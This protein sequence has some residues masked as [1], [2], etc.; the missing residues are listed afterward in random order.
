MNQA[1]LVS[2]RRILIILMG[3]LGDVVRGLAIADAIKASY[4]SIEIDWLVEPK[5]E[6]IVRMSP[7]INTVIVFK[8]A[9]PLRGF[10]KLAS[11]F[12]E[13]SYDIVLD[14]QRHFKSGCFSFLTGAE[15][16]IGFHRRD[17]KE[18]NFL[19]STETISHT[20]TIE[21]KFFH[22]QRFLDALGVARPQSTRTKLL[23]PESNRFIDR[24]QKRWV[25]VTLGSSWLS[26]NW[27]ADSYVSVLRQLLARP[28]IHIVLIGGADQQEIAR[29]IRGQLDHG[30]RVVDAVGQTTLQE[31]CSIIALS[32]AGFGPDSGPGHL[33]AAL[34][35]PYVSLFGPTDPRL[36]APVGLDHLV[37]RSGVG[38][39]PCYRRQCPGLGEVCMRNLDTTRVT[40]KVLSCLE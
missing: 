10:L 4:P 1:S 18:G 13:R 33:A 24:V 36:V 21:N 34:G 35:V 26:K 11:T 27:F 30:D 22:Y 8:R 39:S 28:G 3:A 32:A 19:F 14:L 20:D 40:A 25:F 23:F 6:A 17:T 38:C 12:S 9:Q 5:C 15:R 31:L 37:V 29:Q 16:R 7:S 2:A